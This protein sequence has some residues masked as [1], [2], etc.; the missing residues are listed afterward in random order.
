MTP[1][2]RAVLARVVAGL[3]DSDRPLLVVVDG[4]DGAGKTWFADDLAATLEVS[5]R[6]TVRVSV[7]DFHHPRDHRHAQGR[8]GET[9]WSRSYDYRALRQK[10]L[11]PWC[12]GAGSPYH[13]RHHDLATDEWYDDPVDEVP[14][15]GVLVVDGVF[16]Q[17]EELRDCWDLVVWLEVADDERVR[18]M[19]ARDGVVG[20]VRHRDQR[21]YLDAQRIYRS[22]VD[23]VL[24]ADL[25]VDN[26]D[27]ERPTVLSPD[28]GRNLSARD[29]T[30]GAEPHGKEPPMSTHPTPIDPPQLH[31]N[32]AFA[33]GML[34]PAGPTLWLGGQNGTDAT[35]A[36]LEGL[37]PQTEQALRNILAVLEEAGTTPDH[38]VKL[39]IYLDPS[40]DPTEAYAA[41]GAVWG[42]RRTAVT[43]LAVAPARAGALVEIE[44]VA[45]VP[46]T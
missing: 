36:L 20:D 41:T 11:D 17:R 4:A 44:A 33:W 32:P 15:R 8:T 13:R 37:G 3:P 42:N 26:S 14:G 39:T 46:Q 23:P 16:A 2:R 45:T 27:P 5:G 10:V 35:G 38:V 28:S 34:A 31:H 18:R 43:V 24:G 1:E 12:A 9:V 6:R 30:V 25:V 29:G 21:R 40:V 19:A 22:A 7:D